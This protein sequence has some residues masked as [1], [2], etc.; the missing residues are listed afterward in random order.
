MKHFSLLFIFNTIL[1]LS[2]NINLFT[3]NSI[4]PV[5]TELTIA[6][7]DSEVINTTDST[8][9]LVVFY[10]TKSSYIIEDLQFLIPKANQ[11]LKTK[12]THN[13]INITYKFAKY[14]FDD[15]ANRNSERLL[16]DYN[17][18]RLPYFRYFR[19]KLNTEYITTAPSNNLDPYSFRFSLL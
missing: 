4:Q 9:T 2:Y 15:Y 16:N 18:G 13:N 5:I 3:S 7:F 11:I 17:I 12:N 14:N 10:D 1:S 8:S 6:N 19:S